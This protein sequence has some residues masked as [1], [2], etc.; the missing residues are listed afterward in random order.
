MCDQAPPSSLW[1]DRLENKNKM[2][3][4]IFSVGDR[5]WHTQRLGDGYTRRLGDGHTWKLGTQ[6]VL[7]GW[8]V[9]SEGSL[10]PIPIASYNQGQRK[11]V[12]LKDYRL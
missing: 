3:E 12:T 2:A 11:E 9:V 4:V 6:G 1:C 8:K 7:R 10:S 5:D